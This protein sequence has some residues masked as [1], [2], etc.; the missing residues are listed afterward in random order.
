MLGKLIN[1]CLV[2]GIFTLLFTN[3]STLRSGN[4]NAILSEQKADFQEF[5]LEDLIPYVDAKVEPYKDDDRT[6]FKYL[7]SR[8]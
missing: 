1:L 8:P 3:M 2:Y 5:V 6:L 7:L 4:V